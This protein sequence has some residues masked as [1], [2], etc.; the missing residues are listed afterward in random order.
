MSS[1]RLAAALREVH[2]VFSRPGVSQ[3]PEEELEASAKLFDA[4]NRQ[5]RRGLA[6]KTNTV[7][8]DDTA[9]H[10]KMP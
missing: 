3:I 7:I 2:D 5:L 9:H 6:T 10:A 4:A 8:R 1:K